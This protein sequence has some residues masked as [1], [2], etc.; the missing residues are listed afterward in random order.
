MMQMLRSRKEPKPDSYPQRLLPETTS[1][2][3][4]LQ[5]EGGTSEFIVAAA[6]IDAQ[7]LTYVFIIHW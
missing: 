6:S 1:Q 2:C 5:A 4:T 3:S 7:P